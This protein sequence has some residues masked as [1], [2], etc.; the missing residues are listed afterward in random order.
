ME[1]HNVDRTKNVQTTAL[2]IWCHVKPLKRKCVTEASIIL[3][4]NFCITQVVFNYK[5]NKHKM[6]IHGEK[7]FWWYRFLISLIHLTSPTFKGECV[8]ED[9][10]H[11]SSLPT[12]RRSFV[13]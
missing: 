13:P 7:I 11:E 2:S 5:L 9:P 1:V 3:V 6:S 12:R 4:R 10:T 8:S